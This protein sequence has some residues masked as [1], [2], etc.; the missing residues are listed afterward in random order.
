MQ[1]SHGPTERFVL[2]TYNDPNSV[3]R[4]RIANSRRHVG[5]IVARL[6]P[7]LKPECRETM[8]NFLEGGDVW[9]RLYGGTVWPGFY[10]SGARMSIEIM[11]ALEE[12]IP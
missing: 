6:L 1:K 7:D 11:L 5:E 10:V 2:Y 3:A 8:R 9:Y 4:V 12:E